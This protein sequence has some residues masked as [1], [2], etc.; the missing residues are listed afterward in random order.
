MVSSK[1]VKASDDWLIS[2]IA[3]SCELLQ[4][5]IMVPSLV[6][7]CGGGEAPEWSNIFHTFSTVGG[8]WWLVRLRKLPGIFS[9]NPQLVSL[10]HLT[11]QMRVAE[12]EI[13]ILAFLDHYVWKGFE[14]K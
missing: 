3:N 1:K 14:T 2:E 10:P 8:S 6:T 9:L 4:P 7:L 11:Y 5:H 13:S 12:E